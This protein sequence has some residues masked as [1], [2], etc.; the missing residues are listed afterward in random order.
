VERQAVIY[1][2][3]IVQGVG[4]RPFVYR[5]ATANNLKGFVTNCGDAAVK[6]LVKGTESEIDQFIEQLRQK[7]PPVSEVRSLKIIQ[8]PAQ[9]RFDAFKI[10][11]SERKFSSFES[12]FPPDI[13]ICDDCIADVSNP[14]DRRH[15][16]AFTSC[17]QCGPR[18]TAVD[19][20]PYDRIRTNMTQF[21]MCDDCKKEYLDQSNRRF[22]AQGIC[23]PNCGPQLSL[24]DHNGKAVLVLDPIKEAAK[25]ID[26]GFI[27]AIK[28]IGGF[29]LSTK[30]TEDDP[31]L[32]LRKRKFRPTQ[33]FA[34]MSL[35]LK[36]IKTYAFV[37]KEEEQFLTSWHKPI[38]LLKKSRKY[39]L[40]EF[41]SPGLDTIGVM[42]PYT[43]IH[44]LLLMNSKEPAL[45]MTSGNPSGLPMSITNKHALKKLRDVADYFLLHNRKIINR[46]DDSVFRVIDGAPTFVR[47][48]R[49]YVPISISIPVFNEK[50]LTVTAFGAELRNTGAILYKNNCFL[51]QYIGDIT[52]LETLNYLLQALYGMRRLFKITNDADVIT[53]DAHPQYMTSRLAQE[54]A[55]SKH[56]KLVKVQHHHAHLAAVMAEN[57]VS[58][59]TSVVG[60]AMD[61][62]GY[63]PDGNV[64][65]GEVMKASYS[66]YERLG[67]LR[68]QPMPGGDLCAIYPL[69]MLIAILS[70]VMTERDVYDITLHHIANGLPYGL[71]EF[72]VISRQ[73]R[74]PS[75][76]TS[77]SGR[78][79][80]SIA[81]LTGI[82]YKRTY[83]GEPAM[84]VEAIATQGDPGKL[85][86]TPR[87]EH[88]QGVYSLDT[89]D[90]VQKLADFAKSGQKTAD[91]CAG[92]Q[93]AVA[94]GL[95][96]IAVW[97][98]NDLG[99]DSIVLSGGTAVNDYIFHVI[100]ECVE[101]HNL[102]FIFHHSVPPGDGGISLGQSIVASHCDV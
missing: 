54:I 42:L 28:G 46:C 6:I 94:Q 51:T 23:C 82:C 69:R 65:G 17:S 55:Q 20:L 7:S 2:T 68:Y 99:L 101:I 5:L 13:A 26:E 27:L 74:N 86:L 52:N 45:V 102:H 58:P 15:N 67:H 98:A 77:S 64:W 80:D 50:Q 73:L 12:I 53:C 59:D 29:H 85:L 95:A 56:I 70:T 72:E 78:F 93:K 100:K 60:I 14:N 83:E 30:T 36:T 39:Y 76:F 40:S 89:S 92:A 49:G 1:V 10:K 24:Y 11:K 35:N 47:R 57:G 62:V 21:P 9:D 38:I 66:G 19:E 3:G 87:I 4:F 43:G 18:F 81:A 97:A 16:Y 48:S 41:V 96:D 37:S 25:L 8:G 44:S 34:I 32:T 91:I 79:L 71:K 61:G 75:I 84:R 63:G 22:H 88:H 90:L 33:P 31:I